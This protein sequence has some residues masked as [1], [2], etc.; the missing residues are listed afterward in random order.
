MKKSRILLQI[1]ALFLVVCT[2]TPTAFAT[3]VDFPAS[4]ETGQVTTD[5]MAATTSNGYHT[6]DAMLTYLGG[7]KL[8]ENVASAIV[9]EV[10]S[11]T[12][13][14]ALNPDAPMDPA[15]LVKILTALIA[16]EQGN[17]EDQV[18]VTQEVLDTVPY[19]AVS[20]E[21]QDGE[22][23][24]LK[25]LIHCML[26]G[27]ANDAAAV[28][29]DHI[30][31]DQTSFVKEMN[32]YAQE[33]GCKQTVFMNVHGLFHEQ[34]ITTARDMVRI[35][36]KAMDNAL[37]C[38]FFGTVYY[39][40][41]A[42]NKSADRELSTGNFLMNTDNL[43]I[44]YDARVVGG[45]T[46]VAQD[47]K[48]CLA[49][50]A[51]DGDM[52]MVSVVLGAED[53]YAEDSSRVTI[54]GGYKET[55]KMLDAAFS[56]NKVV[57]I[58]HKGQALTQYSVDNGSNVVVVTPIEDAWAVLPQEV[59]A[60]DIVHRYQQL[61][62]GMSAPITKGSNIASVQLWYG[63][64]CV[65]QTDLVAMNDVAVAPELNAQIS[66]DVIDTGLPLGVTIL[67]WIVGVIVAIILV[68][69]A[70]AMVKRYFM[71]KHIKH[72]RRERRRSK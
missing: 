48:R 70:S 68:L 57:Q 26:V 72:R 8:I 50:A 43:E 49:S 58:L 21:L 62:E 39:T 22:I 56:G 18:T 15:S 4:D 1:I 67:L 47:G 59:Q 31:G 60:A 2:L 29:A 61:P 33:I 55:T 10:G 7:E 41:P 28:I 44:Y 25:D 71:M 9:Y 36:D 17:V 3:E 40:V 12:L 30:S 6:P 11:D 37:F 14:Y 69:R 51:K 23:L 45:R 65:A 52:C 54:F 34:Q 42:T 27:S 20:A 19:D 35:L 64:V 38:E 63:S 5:T 24:S 53:L 16:V 13:M 32:R 46:G 66:E